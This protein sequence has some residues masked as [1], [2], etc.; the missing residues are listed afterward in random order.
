MNTATDTLGL[1]A[2][3]P[4]IA[5]ADRRQA[6]GAG[7]TINIANSYGGSASMFVPNAQ[8]ANI[9]FL[10]VIFKPSAGVYY[11]DANLVTDPL[12]TKGNTNCKDIASLKVCGEGG[13]QRFER[14]KYERQ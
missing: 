10:C 2:V 6:L 4:T 3:T 11:Q 1:A 8:C 5:A 7:A 13:W 9:R 12:D 14:S